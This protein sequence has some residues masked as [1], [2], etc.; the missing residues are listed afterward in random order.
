MQLADLELQMETAEQ[1]VYDCLRKIRDGKLY[2]EAGF[3]S[4]EVYCLERWG[5]SKSY[6]SRLIDYSKVTERLKADGIDHIPSEGALRPL[7]RMKRLSKHED[8]FLD[9]AVEATKIA[10]EH[11]PEKGHIP[12]V[13]QTHVEGVLSEYFHLGKKAPKPENKPDVAEVKR[14]ISALYR[15]KALAKGDGEAFKKKY[16]DVLPIDQTDFVFQWLREYLE[17]A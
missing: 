11:A 12:Q 2:K 15:C 5:W 9:K 13:T 17:S 6:A 3:Q 14:A 8:D 16:G 10:L 7:A 4:F 1:T